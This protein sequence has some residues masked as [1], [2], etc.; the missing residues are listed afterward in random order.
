MKW[1]NVNPVTHHRTSKNVDRKKQQ[2][3]FAQCTSY[4]FVNK[5]AA[6]AIEQTRIMC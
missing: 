4:P 2:L 3:N 6:H 5:L 1:R